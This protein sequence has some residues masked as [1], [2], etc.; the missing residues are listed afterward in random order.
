MVAR[1]P[2]GRCRSTTA[3]AP[4][5]AIT[6]AATEE[7]ERHV[8]VDRVPFH[9]TPQPE[10]PRGND[11]TGQEQEPDIGSRPVRHLRWATK[12]PLLGR[13]GEG[14]EVVDLGIAPLS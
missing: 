7:A 14:G 1:G 5:S 6:I 8:R 12:G 3:S 9:P 10:E 2:G 13:A 4:K 11:Q